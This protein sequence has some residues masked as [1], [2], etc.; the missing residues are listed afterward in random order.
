MNDTQA[1]DFK[2]LF[3]FQTFDLFIEE[4]IKGNVKKKSNK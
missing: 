1:K 4:Y 2:N 3:E